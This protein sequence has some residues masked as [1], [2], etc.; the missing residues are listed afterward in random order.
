LMQLHNTRLE[1][2]VAL[3]KT[4][5]EVQYRNASKERERERERESEHTIDCT[6]ILN[7]S[8]LLGNINKSILCRRHFKS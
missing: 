1:L 2:P 6:Y 4:L 3:V 7:I 8:V 5:H